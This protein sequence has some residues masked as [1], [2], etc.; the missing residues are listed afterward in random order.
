M[1]TSAQNAGDFEY[2][3]SPAEQE[4]PQYVT[5]DGKEYCAGSGTKALKKGSKRVGYTLRYRCPECTGHYAKDASGKINKHGYSKMAEQKKLKAQGLRK[6]FCG[7]CG[8]MQ[9]M[10]EGDFLCQRCRS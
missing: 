6:G 10:A 8:K 1:I 5:I 3:P 9:P 2:L 4:E 7:G